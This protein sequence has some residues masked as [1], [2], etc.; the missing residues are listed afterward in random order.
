MSCTSANTDPNVTIMIHHFEKNDVKDMK[1]WTIIYME[2]KP[3]LDFQ[4]IYTTNSKL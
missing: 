4:H 2:I 1:F 3:E